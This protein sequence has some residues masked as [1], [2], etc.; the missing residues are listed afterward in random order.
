MTPPCDPDHDLERLLMGLVDG[1][2]SPAERQ[3]LAALLRD[4]PALQQQYRDYLLL[5]ALL[6]WEQPQSVEREQTPDP[7]THVTL[8]AQRAVRPVLLAVAAAAVLLA[9]GVFLLWPRA[10]PPG[11]VAVVRHGEDPA[12]DLEVEPAASGLA[13]L[14]RSV[15][16]RW[17]ADSRQP[18]VG[19]AVGPGRLRLE[20]GLVQLEFYS[21]ATLVV[22]G[23]ADLEL[24]SADR[25]RC[26]A[27][28]LRATVPPQA[29]GFTVLS[30]TARLV[31]LG[32]EFGVDVAPSGATELHVFTGKVRVGEPGPDAPPAEQE[33]GAGR[34]LKVE[35][36]G[37]RTDVPV[38]ARRFPTAGEVERRTRAAGAERQEQ[39]RR[40]AE[41]TARDPRV[42][43]YYPF[44]RHTAADRTLHADNAPDGSLDGAIIGCEWVS[45]R[46]PGKQALEFKRPGDRVR[47]TV[48]GR[49]EALTFTAWVRVDALEHK[50]NAL[51]LTDGFGVGAPHWQITEA[52]KLRLC[53]C[54]DTRGPKWV[55]H[56]Y[57]S[58]AAFGPDEL[59]QWKHVATVYDGPGGTVAHYVNGQPAGHHRLRA[60]VVLSVGNVEIGN[61]ATGV[62]PFNGRTDELVLYRAALTP[63]EI[64]ALHRAGEPVR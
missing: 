47:L 60:G 4:D 39:W 28:R 14:T 11:V 34:G 9:T 5:D 54:H 30:D 6:S 50:Y 55:G 26:R 41:K 42:V 59:G 29:R 24:L 17:A 57:D 8:H 27:G 51:F 62:R 49:F 1:E 58:H 37:R 45:G 3:H 36:G 52:G 64:A 16:A 20:A 35:G 7:S 18:G 22:E 48:P 56:T 31:D 32:T 25:L 15:R 12:V 10:Q 63:D 43:L 40:A 46:W 53:V 19:A 33:V 2:L 23:P 61:W 38:D 13:V 44:R 21:G